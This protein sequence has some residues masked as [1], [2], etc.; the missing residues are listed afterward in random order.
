MRD[1]NLFIVQL[2]LL[3]SLLYA[4]DNNTT[5]LENYLS[6]N[7]EEQ[8]KLDFEKNSAE[9]SKLH[10]SWISPINI[11][12]SYSRSNP[13]TKEQVKE[14]AS[15]SIDQTIFQSGGIYFAIK[16]AEASKKYSDLS[17]DVA[18]RKMIKDA[19]SLLMQIK[20]NDLKIQRQEIQ[21]KNANIKLEQNRE[22]YLSGELDSGFLDNAII[23]KN[24]ATQT[25]YD[26]QTAKEKL[27]S[28]FKVISDANYQKL[29]IPEFQ[30]ISK[31]E[32]LAHNIVLD[33]YNSDIQKNKYQNNVTIAKYLPKV[34]ITAGYNWSKSSNLSLSQNISFS[35]EL[36]YYDY[37]FKAYMPLDINTFRD[38]ESSKVDY[39]KSKL[40]VDDKKKE[41]LSLYEQ[42]EQ[43]IENYD[44][45]IALSSENQELYEKL[46]GDTKK[47]FE[48]GY[49]SE[50]DVDLLQNSVDMSKLNYKIL[51]IDKQLELL[52]LYEMWK[53]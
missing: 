6:S 22:Q 29:R 48:V 9:S 5:T 28:Q 43:N 51:N 26:M 53:E 41:L 24:V 4:Q 3:S 47:L 52:S 15:I 46:L 37:G 25:L 49:K 35:N 7:K 50:Y 44:K 39:L 21:I 12:Y 20:Q 10:D 38:I 36:N 45:K 11:N 30:F 14:N 33:M 34:S 27:I 17:I 13:Y 40:V 32:F 16:Y 42:V 1:S 23:E 2:L 18:K 8:F 31:E 19:L